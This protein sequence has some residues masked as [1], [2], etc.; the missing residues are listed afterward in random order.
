MLRPREA[1]GHGLRFKPEILRD[2]WV[3]G[4]EA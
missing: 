4:F 1:S 2:C 3:G